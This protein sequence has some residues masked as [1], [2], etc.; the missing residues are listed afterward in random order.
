LLN[1]HSPLEL[2]SGQ[3]PNISHFRIF[4]CRVWVPVAEPQQKTIGRH[5][6]E[7]IYVGFDSPSIIRYVSPSTGI[8]HKARFQ[9]CQFDESHFLLLASS[10]PSPSLEF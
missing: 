5:R 10:Q 1:D 7:G 6:Q 2:L 3:I 8:L 4:G 9:N